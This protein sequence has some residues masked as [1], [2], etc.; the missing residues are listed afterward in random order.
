MGRTC[1]RVARS[2][3]ALGPLL[4]RSWV[5]CPI[6]GRGLLLLAASWGASGLRQASGSDFGTI[7]LWGLGFPVTFVCLSQPSLPLNFRHHLAQAVY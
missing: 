2:W 6:F 1:V 4:G 7:L 5:R 3:D